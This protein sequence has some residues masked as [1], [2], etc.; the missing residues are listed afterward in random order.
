QRA[1]LDSRPKLAGWSEKPSGISFA[2]LAQRGFSRP[3]SNPA[4]G[5]LKLINPSN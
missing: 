4:P 5:F 3:A 2:T 1:G